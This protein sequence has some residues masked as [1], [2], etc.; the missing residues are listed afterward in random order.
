MRLTLKIRKEL[1]HRSLGGW[2][3]E[4]PRPTTQPEEEVTV[5]V[6]PGASGRVEIFIGDH[7]VV[8]VIALAAQ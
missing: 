5:E 4:T 3:H 7:K 8:L 6:T 2:G 1:N